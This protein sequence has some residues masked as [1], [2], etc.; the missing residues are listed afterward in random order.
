M[1]E[2]ASEDRFVTVARLVRA[3]GN[4]GE[5]AAELESD[6]AAIFKL[7]PEVQ[8]WDGAGRRETAHIRETWPHKNRL[9]LKFDGI[10]TIN[11]AERLAGWEVQIPAALRPP[12]PAGRF[13]IS[14]LIGCRVLEAGSGRLL[15]EV[16][17]LVENGGAPLIH[18]KAG[19]REI[20]VPFA[21]SICVEVDTAARVIRVE[22]PEGLEDLN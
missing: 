8:L 15:G 9:I 14:D 11:Q 20:L 2:R 10:D 21:S 5:V 3:H 4:R 18:V 17:E 22:L 16:T 12:A 6:D 1:P 19:D 7:F 13:Y